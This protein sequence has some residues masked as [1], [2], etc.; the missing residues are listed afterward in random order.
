MAAEGITLMAETWQ[1]WVRR[2]APFYGLIVTSGYRT[3]EHNRAI[4][5]A[6]GSRHT[7]GGYQNPGAID[8]AGPADRLKE[9]FDVVRDR[10]EGGLAELFLNLPGDAWEA[11][12]GNR[13][14]ARN[15]E[16][17]R[18]AHL[19]ISIAAPAEGIPEENRG[20]AARRAVRVLRPSG[21]PGDS[22]YAPPAGRERKMCVGTLA[23]AVEAARLSIPGQKPNPDVQG[24]FC[25]Y[26]SDL[27]VY[28]AATLMVLIGATS[29][30]RAK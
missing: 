15:P 12:K 20:A 2:N 8:V 11:I 6:P 13:P 30:F 22:G 16:R 23:G 19:H 17:G 24:E 3:P 21:E 29:M 1:E 27:I 5:G 10:F 4:G 26:W 7:T 18:P 25:L 14:L 28:T 9:F